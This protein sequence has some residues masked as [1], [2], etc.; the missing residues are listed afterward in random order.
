M[1]RNICSAI[2][3]KYGENKAFLCENESFQAYQRKRLSLSF[4]HADTPSKKKCH[5]SNSF[6]E[7]YKDIVTDKVREWP[8]DKP[9]NWTELGRQC[10]IDQHNAGQKIKEMV[11]MCNID[12]SE[13]KVPAS[14]DRLRRSKAKLPGNEI[15]IPTL[16]TVQES[17]INKLIVEGTLSLGEVCTPYTLIKSSVIDGEIVNVTQEVCGRKI[18]LDE[19][20]Y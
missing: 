14:S 4:N 10:S 13:C 5:V 6:I 12:M 8:K 15:S 3:D 11:E 7:Q 2:E 20:N 17:S 9:I 1:Q 18:S 16:S 19:K